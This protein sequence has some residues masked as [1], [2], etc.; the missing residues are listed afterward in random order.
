MSRDGRAVGGR[1]S[2]DDDGAMRMSYSRLVGLEVLYPLSAAPLAWPLRSTP[3]A[4]DGGEDGGFARVKAEPLSLVHYTAEG[5]FP[6]H[7][8]RAE[9]SI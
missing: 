5:G 8:P 9:F 3:A 6:P 1:T 4:D 7:H 2:V